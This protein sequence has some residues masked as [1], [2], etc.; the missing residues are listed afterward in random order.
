[1]DWIT[2]ETEKKIIK[3]KNLTPDEYEAE[4]KKLVYENRSKRKNADFTGIPHNPGTLSKRAGRSIAA[5]A[6]ICPARLLSGDERGGQWTTLRR[7]I[8]GYRSLSKKWK[9][10][11]KSMRRSRTSTRRYN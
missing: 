4:I 11:D 3:A 9:T 5:A 7:R 6:E 1:M 8:S 10:T 2:Y